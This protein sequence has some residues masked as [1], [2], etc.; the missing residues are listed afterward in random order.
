MI[1]RRIRERILRLPEPP[2]DR[3]GEAGVGAPLRLLVTGDSSAAGVG[4]AHQDEALLGRIVS[5]LAPVRR[6]SWRLEARTG[7]TTARTHAHLARLA[8]EPFDVVITALGVND[9]TAGVG[10]GRWLAMQRQL[11]DLARTHFGARLIVVSGLPPVHLFPALPRVVRWP[12]GWQATRF[13]RAL[14][15][16]VATEPDVRYVNLRFDTDPRLIAEDG[17]HPGPPAYLEWGRRVAATILTT[18]D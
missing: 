15:R 14:A 1:A 17:F 3:R 8:P 9:I 18:L 4:A 5:E 6:V 11:R 16:T 10:R 12:L 13:D 7:S 2:G